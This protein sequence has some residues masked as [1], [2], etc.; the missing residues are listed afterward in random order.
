MTVVTATERI[1]ADEYLAT[2]DDRPHS[3]ELTPSSSTY[4]VAL[5][6][7]AGEQLNSP[8]LDGFALDIVEL[9]GR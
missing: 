7:A 6:L 5:E 3:T 1:G 9:F 8:Q 2:A 4:D